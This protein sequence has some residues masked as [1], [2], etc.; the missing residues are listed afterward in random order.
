MK[1]L[2]LL[3]ILLLPF[4]SAFSQFGRPSNQYFFDPKLINPAFAGLTNEQNYQVQYAGINQSNP[5]FPFSL[6]TGFSLPLNKINS[7]IGGFVWRTRSEP[8]TE[9]G[10]SFLYN[11]RFNLN[12]ERSISIGTEISLSEEQIDN[13]YYHS[14]TPNDPLI[15]NATL[16][17]NVANTNLGVVYRDHNFYVGATAKNLISFQSEPNALSLPVNNRAY[18]AYSS[19]QF[20]LSPSFTLKP[21]VLYLTDFTN[22][23][24]DVNGILYWKDKIIVGASGQ[25][26]NTKTFEKFTAGI[27][28]HKTVQLIGTVYSGLNRYYS[29]SNNAEVMA[30]V[31]LKD[32][33]T[34]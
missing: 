20:L 21:V 9:T 3:L 1:Q 18:S 8:I 17:Y 7:G 22:V 19:Y 30:R 27:I 31:V 16:N 13:S 2:L 15:A 4:R 25:L 29:T 28:L 32:R 34:K 11:Y 6:L 33:A 26:I 24:V 12:N 23:Q 5:N 14:I 10:G